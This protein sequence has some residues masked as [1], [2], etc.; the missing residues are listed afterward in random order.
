MSESILPTQKIKPSTSDPSTM[1]IYG[2]P[3]IGKTTILS[4]LENN[5][6]LDLEGGSKYVEALKIEVDDLLHLSKI[7]KALKAGE[8]KYDFITI[9]TVTKLEEWCHDAALAKFKK[10]QLGSGST[11]RTLAELEYG[12]GYGLWR[13][14]FRKW[15][16]SFKGIADH[17][18]FV[19]HV[20]DKIITKNERDV[21][22]KDINLTG[23]LKAIMASE[24]DAVGYFYLDSTD[25][26]QRKITFLTSDEIT[27]GTRVPHLEGK[28][29]VISKKLDD[30]SVE[31][32]WEE[33]YKSKV[34]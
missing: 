6:I 18:I 24:V 26:S 10:S 4:G 7:G 12:L 32:H 23:Q 27:C 3:K 22:L 20:K 33:I 31:T 2:T 16:D 15:I 9:D 13:T 19:G 28:E 8:E 30:G 34:K 5:L 1:F 11:A 21:S 25:H 17:I 29:F 14:E